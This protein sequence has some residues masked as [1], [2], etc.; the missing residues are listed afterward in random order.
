MD[1]DIY[2]SE[3]EENGFYVRVCDAN[4][5]ETVHHVYVTGSEIRELGVAHV[6]TSRVLQ[7]AFLF[8][9]ENEPPHAIRTEFSLGE[10]TQYFPEFPNEIKGRVG[11]P[12]SR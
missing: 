10:I 5:T 6:S 4:G 3:D 7:H 11:E 9:L 2:I 1:Y 12:N 8:L